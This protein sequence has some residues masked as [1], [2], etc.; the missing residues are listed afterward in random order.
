MPE[1]DLAL[2]SVLEEARQSTG[3]SDFGDERFREGLAVL[4][5]TYDTTANLSEKGRRRFRR[6]V[7]QLLGQ[8][9]RIEEAFKKHPEIRERRIRRRMYLTG[10][11][12]TRS[13][14]RSTTRTPTRPR[15]A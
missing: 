2:E 10:A 7:V 14:P 5:E 12:R 3:L 13:S 6:R 15:S 11:R 9:L 8:R 4:L 1:T